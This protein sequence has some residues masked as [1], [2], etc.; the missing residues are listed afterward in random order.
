VDTILANARLADGSSTDILIRDGTIAGF[1]AAA[2]D[3]AATVDLAGRLVLPAL[4]D[5]HVHLDKTLLGLPWHPHAAANTTQGRIAAE[6]DLRRT[7]AWPVETCGAEL[8]RLALS[9]GTTAVR[10]HVDI[11]EVT[12]LHNVEAVL[13]LRQTWSPFVD[14]E[15]VAFPQSGLRRCPGA[16]ELLDEAVRMGCD[17]VGDLDPL[18]IDDDLNGHLD[19]IFNLAQRHGKGLDIHLHDQGEPGLSEILA[20]AARTKAG[21][22]GGRVTVS[23]AFALG[24]VAPDRAAFAAERLAETGV[25]ILTSAPGAAPMPPV[26]LL[27]K[28][29]VRVVAGSDNIRDA[30]SP[31]GNANML[32]RCWLTAQR[33]GF[34]TDPDVEATFD[35]A[36]SNAASLLGLRRGVAA[37]CAA[38]LIAVPTDTLARTIVERPQP[39]LVLRRGRAVHC[40]AEI[41]LGRLPRSTL[42]QR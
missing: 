32:E 28:A 26:A 16:S 5:A 20:I 1:G 15:I 7:L 35:L 11:D 39:D 37:G 30:W 2:P 31:F 9:H 10:T 24:S 19:A 34:R 40:A 12:G 25:T 27:R 38:D 21:G 6:K 41:D 36:T 13:R 42:P 4:I 33:C 8:L 29:G 18:G 3:G 22:L 14:I 17:L 23:H